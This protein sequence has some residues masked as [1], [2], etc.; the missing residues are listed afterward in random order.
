MKKCPFCAEE[1]QDE[2]VKCRFCGSS[3]GSSAAAQAAVPAV[4]HAAVT[5][6][7]PPGTGKPPF[8]RKADNDHPTATERKMLY[9]GSPSWRS[10]LGFYALGVL[11]TILVP[12]LLNHFASS[13]WAT[14][15]RVL[16]VMIPLAIA[17]VYFAGLHF[18]RRSLRFRVTTTNIETEYGILSK[19]IDVIELWR[20]RDVGYR[21]TLMDRLLGIAHIDITSSDPTTPNLCI[22]GLPASRELFEKL[23]DCIEIQRQSKN[24]YGVVS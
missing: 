23:R 24:V 16:L 19:R 22:V 9:D 7:S 5:E 13:T 4:A 18:H 17:A 21:Q 1:I 14:S 8:A 12:L 15:T 10:Y 11:G 2:A 20:C 3:I 6:T